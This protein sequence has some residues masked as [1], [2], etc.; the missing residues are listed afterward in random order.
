V[1]EYDASDEVYTIMWDSSGTSKHV[2]RLN[3]LFSG[4]S[5][6]FF[7]KR[8][9]EARRRRAECESQ[10]R[11]H[12]YV[13]TRKFRNR[14]VDMVALSTRMK[15]KIGASTWSEFA[16]L[17]NEVVQEI[18]RDYVFAVKKGIVL[19]DARTPEGKDRLAADGVC[20]CLW[21]AWYGHGWQHARSRKSQ[22][23]RIRL[24]CI[25]AIRFGVPAQVH[26]GAQQRVL[27]QP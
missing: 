19:Y 26:A 27:G 4:E 6:T 24:A 21:H 18:S 1:L 5:R 10:A 23:Q 2:K 8:L 20:F 9:Q 15:E 25:P 11:F 16:G 17:F 7:R 14:G 12:K 13:A 22:A 3:L